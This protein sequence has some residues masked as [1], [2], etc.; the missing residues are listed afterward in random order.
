[1]VRR[2]SGMGWAFAPA[3]A[4]IGAGLALDAG[5]YGAAA[6]CGLAFG[7][8]VYVLWTIGKQKAA[9]GPGADG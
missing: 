1:M 3:T 7:W 9:S 2:D 8:A 4:L 6:G 5:S